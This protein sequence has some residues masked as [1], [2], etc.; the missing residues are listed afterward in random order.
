MRKNY[1]TD[2]HENF[3]TDVTLDNQVQLNFVSHPD[4]KSGSV[5][6]LR[7][8]TSDP[9][10][11]RLCGGLRSPWALVSAYVFAQ[12]G[13]SNTQLFF[14]RDDFLPTTRH[15][16]IVQEALTQNVVINQVSKSF[17]GL[18][19]LKRPLF[20]CFQKCILK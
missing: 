9:G 3:T 13:S 10:Q 20:F 14:F 15:F 8:R 18:G 12:I 19:R 7:I 5:C 2:L 1:W 17:T 4:P 6:G 11:I 16:T